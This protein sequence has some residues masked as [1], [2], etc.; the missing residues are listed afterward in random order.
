MDSLV[1][2]GFFCMAL[3]V[4]RELTATEEPIILT[5]RMHHL[6]IPGAREWSSFPERA[7]SDRLTLYFVAKKAN[8]DEWTLCLTQE[9]IKQSWTVQLNGNSIGTLPID[10]NRM[11]VYFAIDAGKVREGDN[12]LSIS[13]KSKT[14][15]DDVRV[16]KI[17]VLQQPRQLALRQ[18]TIRVSVRDKKSKE[19]CPSR[20]TILNSAGSLQSVGGESN[21]H[22]AVRPGIVYTSSG[23]A[24]FGVPA[25]TYTII[26]AR[27]FEYSIDKQMVNLEPGEEAEIDLTIARQV[28]TRGYVSCDPHV[29]TRTH[30]GHGDSTVKERMI[31]LAAEGIELPIATD[32][33]V[34]IDHHPFAIEANVR[35]YFTPV[36]GNEVTTPTAHFNIFPIHADARVP[37]HRS[38]SW[39][40]T[41]REIFATPATKIAILNHGRDVHSGVTPLGPKLFN[42][43]SGTFQS[44]WNLQA[45]GMELV[46]S[47]ATQT[48][49]IQLFHDWMSLL[50]FGHRITPVG[51]S[52]SHDVGRHFVGQARTYIR[53]DDSDPSKINVD[54]AVRSF[55]QGEVVVS[56]GLFVEMVVDGKHQSGQLASNLADQVTVQLRVTAPHWIQADQVSLFAN[57]I[58]IKS[59]KIAFNSP[60]KES[61]LEWKNVWTIDRPRHDVHLVAIATGPGIPDLH[62]KTA[63]PYLPKSPNWTPRVIG[64]SGAIWL[65]VDGDSKPT[66]ARQY[67]TQI[68]EDSAG[69]LKTMISNLRTYD[70]S[71]A[72]QVAELYRRD[73]GDLDSEQF[74][75]TLQAGTTETRI[76]FQQYMRAWRDCEIAKSDQ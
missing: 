43:A 34:H 6:R 42:S 37:N 25:G 59:E 74:R 24:E 44:G 41:F 5:K 46:N 75:R 67:A 15:T 64:C 47:S 30:S 40:D 29:H 32:H 69:D 50:N 62:W 9:D 31:T 1:R 28:D 14:T 4:G 26:S 20:I 76:G 3:F 33:N 70:K 36:I 61:E 65:D 52:D 73:G 35:T 22:L 23:I 27:G 38:T 51:S 60:E 55:L 2:L 66:N 11:K 21:Q 8:S 39:D 16:G 17:C 72:I 48:D 63:K 19:H 7:E 13:Q 18:A 68:V 53:C 57:G 49:P 54:E 71:V 58:E 12:E 45:N 10:E 56:Y